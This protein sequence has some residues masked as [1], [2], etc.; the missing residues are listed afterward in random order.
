LAVTQALPGQFRAYNVGTG[1]GYSVREV[2]RT[3]EKV[4]G[5][6]VKTIDGPRRAGDPPA[7]VAA[8]DRILIDLGWTPQYG[9]LEP[10]IRTAWDWHRRH[11]DGYRTG[12]A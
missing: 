8:A 10:I 5:K 6:P 2:I 9:E 4:T 11:P 1:R 3:A 12:S 7:L